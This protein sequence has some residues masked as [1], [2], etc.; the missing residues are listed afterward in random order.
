MNFSI[1]TLGCPK[2]QVDSENLIRRLEARG[3]RYRPDPDEAGAVLV[4]TCAFITP[5]KEES[6]ETILGL[7]GNDRPLLVLGCLAERYREELEREIPEAAAFFGV[8]R[9]EEIADCLDRLDGGAGRKPA[10]PGSQ[11]SARPLLNPGHYAY[12]KIAEGCDNRCTY[13]VIP[14][15]RGPYRSTPPERL[16]DEARELAARGVKELVVVAQDTTAWGR[17]FGTGIEDLLE[18]LAD[19]GVPWIRL[20]YSYPDRISDRLLGLLA[21][22]PNLLPYLDM[23]LQH[24]AAGVLRR[25]GRAGTPDPRRLVERIRGRLPGAVIR[26][27]VIVGFPGETEAEFEDLLGF[28]AEARLERLGAFLYSPEEGTPAA[29]LPDPVPEERARER[30]DRLMGLQARISYER[31]R[32]LVGRRLRVLVDECEDGVALAR[33]AADAPEVDAAVILRGA[34]RPGDFLEA[35]ITGAQDYD[36]EAEAV[37]PGK[38]AAEGAPRA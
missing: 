8:G 38:A 17:E 4:N 14:S 18:A 25:M 37:E 34:Y 16:L 6:I 20:M 7:L 9:E 29:R 26:S 28:V 30:L 33:S 22:R 5:A 19:T 36:L 32:A 10:G 31:N 13:C 1:V 35:R 27:T 2:N 23:P 21:E 15:I 12:L 24:T 11:G 3:H